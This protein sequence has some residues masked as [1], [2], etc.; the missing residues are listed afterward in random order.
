VGHNTGT[1]SDTPLAFATSDAEKMRDVFLDLG[2]V[3]PQDATL[4]LHPTARQ[5]QAALHKLGQRVAEAAAQGQSTSL[6]FYYSGHGDAEG[7]NLGTTHLPHTSLR[8][9]LEATQADVRVAFVDACVRSSAKNGAW[10][11]LSL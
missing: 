10:V 8:D 9:W 11:G 3:R 4:L 7:L 6:V 2:G 1:A 5:V